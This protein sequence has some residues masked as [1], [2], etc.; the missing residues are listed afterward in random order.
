MP[1]LHP[2]LFA[3]FPLLAL[4]VRNMDQVPIPQVVAALVAAAAG[5][6]LLWG[7]LTLLT[8]DVRKAA[9][10]ATVIVLPCLSYGHLLRL[11]PVSVH[12]LIAPACAIAAGAAIWAAVKTRQPLIDTTAV[13]NVAAIFLVGSSCFAIASSVWSSSRP[14]NQ[15][16]VRAPIMASPGDNAGPAVVPSKRIHGA[17]TSKSVNLPDV[18]YIILDA[19]GRADR[20][21][22]F[23]GYDNTPFINELEKRGF[24][25]ADHS[26]G[27][28]DETPLCLASSLNLTYLDEV[29]K[30]A[31]PNGKT[32]VC[33][34]MLDDNAV[35]AYLSPLGYRYVYIG[36][37]V[38]EAKVTTADIVLNDQPE[39]ASFEQELLTL[40]GQHPA[41]VAQ[42]HRF[43][44]HRTRLLGV[45]DNLDSVARLPF[46]KFVFAHLLAPH[47]PFVFGP[48]GE[49]VQ[50]NTGFTFSDGSWLLQ[51]ITRE[52]YKKGY[53]DQLQ[54]VNR[55]TLQAID[56]ILAQSKR[57]PIIIVQGDHGSRMNLDW[58]SLEKTDLREPF[59]ILNAYYVPSRVRASLYDTISP[60]NSFRIVLNDVF[61][62]HYPLLPDRS[63]YST[64]DQPLAFTDVTARTPDP[65]SRPRT[66]HS[67]ASR[68]RPTGASI[69]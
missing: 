25:V 20:L 57:P 35:A 29:A 42:R 21:K 47:P 15:S 28:Y 11:T 5:A 39:L 3:L 12:W 52:E 6:L 59:S 33:R 38:G 68:V 30:Q 54:Y 48:N 14:G 62:A 64:A 58:D 22:T 41:T 19:Y 34:R 43:D 10:I 66:A 23:Y 65:H 31:G 60:V 16:T 27:N 4:Y 67:G 13:L 1:P 69:Q 49:P 9:V 8:R 36:S 37:G 61:G 56:A 44:A 2:V 7:L 45:F 18:Y 51:M 24:Y 17:V 55:R 26:R 46:K 53:I 40:S 63:F 50:Q 32:E